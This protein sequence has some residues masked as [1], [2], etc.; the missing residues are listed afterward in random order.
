M[1]EAKKHGSFK[2]YHVFLPTQWVEGVPSVI[3]EHLQREYWHRD[4]ILGH[5][6]MIITFKLIV[7]GV[8]LPQIDRQIYVA[9]PQATIILEE[10]PPV[11]DV[12]TATTWMAADGTFHKFGACTFD[13][14]A[15]TVMKRYTF[16][17]TFTPTLTLALTL[18][19]PIPSLLPTHVPHHDRP[20]HRNSW[21]VVLG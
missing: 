1:A 16:T 3:T 8:S 2:A 19:H 14:V 20:R 10:C 9:D 7:G 4:F 11:P 13:A 21:R 12:F 18:T 5:F 6:E 17:L 15:K